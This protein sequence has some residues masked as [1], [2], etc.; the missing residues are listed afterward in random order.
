MAEADVL[1]V[2]EESDGVIAVE[3]GLFVLYRKIIPLNAGAA[4]EAE[5]LIKALGH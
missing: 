2:E 1:Q 3:P 5:I 4:A